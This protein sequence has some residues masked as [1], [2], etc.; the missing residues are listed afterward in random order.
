M[1]LNKS[2]KK[3]KKEERE[4]LRWSEKTKALVISV[5]PLY[6]SYGTRRDLRGKMQWG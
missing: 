5:T 3:K 2:E 1:I 6:R 4:I